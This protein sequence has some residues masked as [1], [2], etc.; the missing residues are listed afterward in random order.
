MLD[1]M[2]KEKEIVIITGGASRT[3]I[4]TCQTIYREKLFC[5]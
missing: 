5:M 3:R 4:R 1:K 2:K